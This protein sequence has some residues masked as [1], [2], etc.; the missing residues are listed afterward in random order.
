MDKHLSNV[1]MTKVR[2]QLTLN[3]YLQ[4]TH[5]NRGQKDDSSEV[6]KYMVL[7]LKTLYGKVNR[8][9]TVI[10]RIRT[11]VNAF[12]SCRYSKILFPVAILTNQTLDG[13]SLFLRRFNVHFISLSSLGRRLYSVNL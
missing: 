8:Y 13:L 3:H 12:M 9:V 4:V 2:T 11:W 1:C 7:V 5:T 6:K 10:K